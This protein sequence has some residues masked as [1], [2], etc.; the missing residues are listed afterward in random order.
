MPRSHPE[1]RRALGQ[2]RTLH[3]APERVRAAVFV[4]HPAFFDAYDELQV[5]YEM[6]RAHFLDGE[7][8]TTVCAAFGY[9]RQ[10]FYLLRDRLAHRGLAG[11]RD[12]RPGPVGPRTCTPAVVD[13]LRA[14]RADDP[15][16]SIPALLDRLEH[17]HGVRLHRRTVERIVGGGPRKKTPRGGEPV[18]GAAPAPD[19][20]AGRFCV[21]GGP[22]QAEYELRRA[23]FLGWDSREGVARPVGLGLAGLAG[24]LTCPA[25][26]W[27]VHC[28][29]ARPSRWT[30]AVDT[31]MTK[32]DE[33][34]RLILRAAPHRD[35]TTQETKEDGHAS[36]AVRPRIDRTPGAAGHD[37]V[38]TG[39][40]HALGA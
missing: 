7:P 4:E 23:A 11:L 38:A 13:F 33:A 26:E 21:A 24:L 36:R 39:C 37:R 9:S 6:L 27:I 1:K 10:T 19:L 32:L 34:Y 28:V 30:G 25:T 15:A 12:A 31:R 35:V 17:T 29:A 20:T 8:V 22:A 16:L 18:A 40:A 5:K 2:E 3:P 14:Q